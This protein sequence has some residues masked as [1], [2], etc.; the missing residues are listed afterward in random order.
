MFV[1]PVKTKS[2]TQ[3]K[4]TERKKIRSN[5]AAKF[6]LSEDDLNKLFP[7]KGTMNQV[8]VIVHSGQTVTVLT[9]DKRP[10]FFEVPATEENSSTFLLPT[11][12]AMWILPELVPVFTTHAAVL[13]RLA[14]GADLMLPGKQYVDAL[15]INA[16]LISSSLFVLFMHIQLG[17]IKQGQGTSTYGRHRR[18]TVVAVNLTSNRSA[19]GVGLLF[20]SSDDLFMANNSGICVKM[21]HVFGDKLWSLETS[22]CLQVP[23]VGA[24]IALPTAEDFPTLGAAKQKVKKPDATATQ[25]LSVDKEIDDETV[26]VAK[27]T[28]ALENTDFSSN[29]SES[30][31]DNELT[32]SPDDLLKIA[33]ITAI[34]RMGKTPPLPMLTS[35]F[36]RNHILAVDSNIDLKQ[37]TYKKISKFLQA[38]CEQDF[39]TVREETKGVEKITAINSSHPEVVKF[40][41]TKRDTEKDSGTHGLF[42]SEMKELYFVTDDTMKFFNKF[43][44]QNGEGI[45]PAQVKKYVKEYVCNKKL[46]DSANIRTI[47]V[48]ELIA[49]ICQLPPAI[50]TLQ[51][52]ELLSLITD[53]MKHSYAMRNKNELRTGGKQV[54]IKMTLATRSGNKKVTLIDNL[55]HFGIRLPE[56]AQACK[57]GVAASTAITQLEGPNNTKRA[58]MLIQGNQIRFLYKLLTETYKIPP[59]YI[60]GLDLAKKEKKTNKK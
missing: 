8:K 2:N 26:T 37:T 18:D 58:Q 40:I 29:D 47:R 60:A 57:V 5:V 36:Y 44:V 11:V 54:A 14:A 35:N 34:K 10:L 42:L 23:V 19:I 4:S 25:S 38:M 55:E 21:F 24:T 27:V 48:D 22:V 49:E 13:P 46:Q 9:N 20:R 53:K 31:G 45:E 43:D 12:Y 51:F 17:V 41:L 32:I 7:S 39:I 3:V 6:N 56:F 30:D 33:F 52:D 50:K 59:K 15:S 16:L 28:E 1:K